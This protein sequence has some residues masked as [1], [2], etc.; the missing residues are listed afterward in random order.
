[1]SDELQQK[2][3]LFLP[4]VAAARV[5]AD[6]AFGQGVNRGHQAA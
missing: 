1:M 5:A 4:P 3:N 6:F 2:P